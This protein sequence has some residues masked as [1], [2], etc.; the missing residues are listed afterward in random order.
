MQFPV[1]T[2][3]MVLYIQTTVYRQNTDIEKNYEYASERGASE[4]GKFLHFQI[5]KLLFPSLV[6]LILYLRNIFS[7]LK[8]KSAWY[9]ISSMQFPVITYGM[10]LYIQ[11]T[12]YRQNNNIEKIYEY[13]SERRTSE[14]WKCLHFHILKLLFPSIF[15]WYFWYFISETYIF[16]GL[17]LQSESAWY[18]IISSMQF[19]VLTY[20]MALYKRQY[21]DKTLTMIKSMYMRASGASELRKFSHFYILK[22]LFLSIFCWYFRYF[23]GTNE[24]LVGL[25]VPTKFRKSMREIAPLLPSGHANVYS[26]CIF[27]NNPSGILPDII[28]SDTLNLT[29][30]MRERLERASTQRHHVF[31]FFGNVRLTQVIPGNQ[32]V[33][34]STN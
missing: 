34:L 21:T 26:K 8:L 14:L 4:L 32:L 9:L 25:H 31:S 2:Y 23:V 24:M 1:I 29:S 11:K 28:A 19:P 10:A 15:C 13:A 7:G 12:V 20:G 16:S 18:I 33:T 30:N 27:P 3:G 6:L 22:L 5:L 17:K